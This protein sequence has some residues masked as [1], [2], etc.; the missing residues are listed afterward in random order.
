MTTRLRTY[1][2]PLLVVSALVV[3]AAAVPAGSAVAATAKAVLLGKANSATT[4]TTITNSK[5]TPLALNAKKGTAP[6]K[7]N[8]TV[9]VPNLNADRLDGLSSSAFA[10]AAGRTGVVLK[11]NAPAIC[12]KG[13]I[14]TG[15]GGI[16]ATED[17]K[18]AAIGYSGPAFDAADKLI[19]NSWDVFAVD[20]QAGTTAFAVCYSPTGAKIAGS[21][22][23]AQAQQKLA[24]VMAARASRR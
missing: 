4:T 18:G 23:A 21:I 20:E 19:P 16:A 5:G 10:R 12:P 8:S 2:T 13:T 6:L 3:G 11:D 1:R 15:G 17:G 14:L 22:T 9:V 24:R 7:V